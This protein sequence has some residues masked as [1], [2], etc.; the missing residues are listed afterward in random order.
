MSAD[1]KRRGATP[2]LEGALIPA[3]EVSERWLWAYAEGV[4]EP[5]EEAVVRRRIAAHPGSRE[6]LE[7]IEA[8]LREAA[9]RRLQARSVLSG[10]LERVRDRA[11]R[12]VREATPSGEEVAFVVA[13]IRGGLVPAWLGNGWEA[14]SRSGGQLGGAAGATTEATSEA[15]PPLAEFR[16][17]DGVE[18]Q[19]MQG[20]ANDVT[21]RIRTGDPGAAGPVIV[22]RRSGGAGGEPG[23]GWSKVPG[24]SGR[25]K[26][27]VATLR[28]V[29][30]GLLCVE[31][32]G[33]RRLIFAVRR[34]EE[35]PG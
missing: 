16:T 12:W 3:P 21:L 26:G 19:V 18:L 4:L 30:E 22:S 17:P 33:G 13:R 5:E 24:A 6:K 35:T 34:D 29:P 25:M 11:A 1:A 31:L 9:A 2:D 23:T 8:A 14:M 28:Q 27:G 10:W 20:G 15:P 32:P 7:R